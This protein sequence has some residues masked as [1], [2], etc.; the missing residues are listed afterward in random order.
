MRRFLA[1]TFT[2]LTLSACASAL[3]DA[4]QLVEVRTPGANDAVCYLDNGDTR[5]RVW[6]PG[7]VTL[8]KRP[9]DLVV[10]C[11]ADGNRRKT[12]TIEQQHSALTLGNAMNGF[13]PG[14]FIDHETGAMFEY[15]NVITVDFTE[16]AATKMPLPDYHKHLMENPELFGMEEFRPGRAALIRDK[17]EEGYELQ[18]RDTSNRATYSEFTVVTQG[19]SESSQSSEESS[20]SSS[21]DSSTDMVS[22]LTKQMNPQVF[23][24][25]SATSS[26][27]FAGGTQTTGGS[28]SESSPVTLHPADEQ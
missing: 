28:S 4:Q 6:S 19:A 27:G 7:K 26:S 5:H 21:V 25:S 13:I 8:S 23:D 16:I 9:G 20:E 2:A 22:D 14:M 3:G 1:L 15:P 24:K 10:E 12:V 17:Y 11:L 18:K